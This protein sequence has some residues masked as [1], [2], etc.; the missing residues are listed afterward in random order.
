MQFC[1]LIKEI[2]EP[3]PIPHVSLWCCATIIC[4]Q[5][6]TSSSLYYAIN[7]F[8]NKHDTSEYRAHVR[9][10]I[11]LGPIP[12][13]VCLSLLYPFLPP[14][15][16]TLQFCTMQNPLYCTIF[17]YQLSFRFCF[18]LLAFCWV[19][20]KTSPPLSSPP[21][22]PVRLVQQ[23]YWILGLYFPFIYQL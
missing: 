13:T 23:W 4:Q 11:F 20:V 12:I 9:K 19:I 22:P 21:I 8:R 17:I 2:S 6:L 15:S 1:I 16:I 14:S 5:L 3:S 10:A 18:V 7:T